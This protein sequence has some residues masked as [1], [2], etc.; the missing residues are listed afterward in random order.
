MTSMANRSS[1][2]LLRHI[3]TLASKADAERLSDRELLRRFTAER[4]E[5]AFAD[6]VRRHGPM[7][8]GVCRRVL[9]QAQDAEDVFQAA[10]LVLAQKA[11]RMRWRESVGNWLYGVAYRLALK[12][13]VRAARRQRR[14][15]SKEP[16]RQRAL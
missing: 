14:A 12:A 1:S 6:L 10:F 8:Q 5:T 3:R 13:K 9:R 11:P 2:T 4:D 16:K 15:E 7:V